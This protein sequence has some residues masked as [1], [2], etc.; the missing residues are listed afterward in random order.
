MPDVKR[1]VRMLA[2]ND[3]KPYPKNTR[4][5]SDAQIDQIAA[6]LKEFE[7]T[8]PVLIDENMGVIAGH[9][10]LE[11]A[12]RLDLAEIPCIELKGLTEAQ[13]QAYAIADNR[14]PLNASWNESLL[15][16][17]LLD[18]QDAEFDLSLLGFDASEIADITL[19]KEINQPEYDESTAD[20][21]E[22][23]TCPECGKSFPK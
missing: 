13:K 8:N 11:A 17:E 19:G 23:V 4:M 3:L 15:R 21:V 10:R 12:K 6:S 7:W 14:L 5:H 16:G 1:P 2:I 18:L 20:S 9:A 22:M